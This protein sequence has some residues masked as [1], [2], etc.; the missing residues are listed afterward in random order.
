MKTRNEFEVK[1]K[2][3]NHAAFWL[4]ENLTDSSRAANQNSRQKVRKAEF[5]TETEIKKAKKIQVENSWVRSKNGGQGRCPESHETLKAWLDFFHF[6]N[7]FLYFLI[8]YI[9]LLI[10]YCKDQ[11][12][13]DKSYDKLLILTSVWKT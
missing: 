9:F 7:L 2:E 4:A 5:R 10:K 1:N 13:Y 6:I 11:I 8:N 12:I 3:V